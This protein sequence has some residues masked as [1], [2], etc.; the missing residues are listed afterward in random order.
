MKYL[1]IYLSEDSRVNG[2]ADILA[3]ETKEVVITEAEEGWTA[4]ILE[5]GTIDK[6]A[7]APLVEKYILEEIEHKETD[8]FKLIPLKEVPKD[9]REKHIEYFYKAGKLVHKGKSDE[10]VAQELNTAKKE[11]L[12]LLDEEESYK[13]QRQDI[14]KFKEAIEVA[15]FNKEKKVTLIHEGVKTPLTIAK[16]KETVMGYATKSRDAFF[17]KSD[18]AEEINK[19]KNIKEL[20]KLTKR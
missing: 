18:K 4:P 20:E 12:R 13:I 7:K 16:A 14:L 5:D 8:T 9:F 2:Y 6:E 11:A 17:S 3:K 15:E 19:A 1:Y 10:V